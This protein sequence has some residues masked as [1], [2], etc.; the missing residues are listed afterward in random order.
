MPRRRNDFIPALLLLAGLFLSPAVSAVAAEEQANWVYRAWQTDEGLPD[1]SVTGVAQTSDG[2]LW[3]A[4]YGGLMR[5]NGATFSGIQLPSLLKKSIRTM[6]LDRRGRFWLGIDTGS[7]VCLESNTSRIFGTGD[8]LPA[9]RVAAT[10]EDAAGGIWI[11]YQSVLCRIKD[12]QATRFGATNGW[13]A[14]INAWVTSDA[15][16]NV[17]FSKGGQVGVVHDRELRDK[18]SFKETA[19]RLCGAGP[20]G[21]WISAGVRLLKYDEQQPPMEVGQLPANAESQVLFEDR[22]GALWIGT[23]ADGLFRFQNG[24]LEKVPTS[25]QSVYCLCEDREGNLWAG[26][27]GGGLDLIRPSAVELIG[28]EAGLPFESVASVC[29]D[30]EGWIWV[31]SQNGVLARSHDGRWEVIGAEAGWTGDAATCVAADKD[32]GVWVGARNRSLNYFHNGVWRTWQ[33]QDGLHNGA[34][35]LIFVARNNDVWVVTGSPS[36]LQRLRAGKIGEAYELPGDNR[37]IRTMA[38]GAD[39]TLWIGTLEGQ[40]LRVTNST[41]V[42]EAAVT[43]TNGLPVRT[44]QTTADNT[45]WIGYAGAG[46]GCL[47][48]GTFSRVTTAEGLMDDFASQL[49]PDRRGGMWIVGNHGLFEVPVAELAAVAADRTAR[50]RSQIFGRNEGLPNFQPNT[51]GFPNTCRG[52]DGRLWFATRSG[53]LLVRPESIRKNPL[54]PPVVLERVTVDDKTAALYDARTPLQTEYGNGW[55]DLRES[56]AGLRVPPK[57]RKLELEF[58][59]L[60]FASPENIQFRYKLDNFDED[61]IEGGSQHSARYPHLP[62]GDYQFHVRACNNAGVWNEAGATLNIVV[63]P[64]YWQTWWFRV[65]VLLVFTTGV[66]AVVRYVSFRR[67]RAR[68]VQLEH[69]AALEKERARIARDMHDEV[70]AKL[71]RLSLLT[72]MAGGN[73]EMPASARGEVKEISDTARETIRS[74]E[75]IVWAVNPRNDTL[76][77]L[78]HYLCRYAEDYFDGS[79]VQCGF[80]LPPVIAPVVLPPEVRQ[81]VFLAAKEALNNVLKHAKARRVRLRLVVGADEFKISIEDDGCG[82]DPASPPKRT[83]GG[84]GLDNMRERLRSVGGRC[85]CTSQ[86][87]QGT[88]I[89]FIAPANWPAAN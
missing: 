27:R 16:G 18:L 48:G 25:Q 24:T 75:E 65:L 84:N 76:A 40:I 72:E 3:V 11:A 20:S 68:M 59:A 17:W 14:G 60:S 64:F 38:E 55:L 67:L 26:T 52:G 78:V 66:V 71:T 29:E 12:G 82:F 58:S 23:A 86:P 53:L 39:G 36:R 19:I 6:L 33:R 62:A 89:T 81:Q 49:L 41:L 32:G 56:K 44:V 21:L 45:L 63:S 77:D 31:A 37:T 5:F 51:A 50:L 80:D 28:R 87:G 10:A 35:H 69:Q 1:N 73:P 9:E 42:R 88:G 8:G 47:K 7:V 61:W 54:P 15:R 57:H 30:T 13:P 22:A 34:V 85:E 79:P 43:E 74:F 83:G 2:Y 4:T 70:G 46:V